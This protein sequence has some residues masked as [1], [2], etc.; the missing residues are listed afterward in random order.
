[1]TAVAVNTY[2]HS[3]TYV[4]DNILK[5]FKDIVRLSG[6]NPTSL[7]TGWDDNMRALKAWLESRHLERVI[8]EIY[9]PTTNRLITRWDIDVIYNWSTGDGS[10]WC[11]TEQLKYAILKTGVAPSEA[12]YELLMINKEGR[13][14]VLGWSPCSYRSTDGMVRHS[15]GGTIEHNGLGGS[16]AYWRKN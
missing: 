12:K 14:D 4:A 16:S 7:V 3:V 9:D 11:D 2:T 10:F 5:S 6:L 15:L 8:L 1:M 13:P